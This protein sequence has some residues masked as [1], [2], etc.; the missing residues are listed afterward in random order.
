MVYP[1]W[2]AVI[3][4]LVTGSLNTKNYSVGLINEEFSNQQL[5]YQHY[6]LNPNQSYSLQDFN[7][8][9][10]IPNQLSCIFVHSLS[11]EFNIVSNVL[12]KEK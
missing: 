2:I 12:R 7:L 3:Y 11:N 9:C 4:G 1:L 6:C 10:S 5:S 8:T